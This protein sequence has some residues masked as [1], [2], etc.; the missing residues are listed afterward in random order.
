M[1][2]S[3]S[4]SLSL[5]L[6]LASSFRDARPLSPSSSTSRRRL[7][8]PS[9]SLPPSPLSSLCV[10]LSRCSL[11][12]LRLILRVLLLARSAKRMRH[13]ISPIPS[14]P[15]PLIYIYLSLFLSLSS[16]LLFLQFFFVFFSRCGLPLPLTLHRLFART[17]TF[18]PLFPFSLFSVA[19]G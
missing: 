7:F 4:P 17:S 11:L 12:S 9:P 10:H 19:S 6:S 15:L 5:S 3:A 18:A 8:L 13:S 14:F 1:V 16:R 2:I